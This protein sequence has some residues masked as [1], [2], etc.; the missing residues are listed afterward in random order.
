MLMLPLTVE[1]RQVA[2]LWLL[3]PVHGQPFGCTFVDL[4]RVRVHTYNNSYSRYV[5]ELDGRCALDACLPWHDGAL[6]V[7]V[8]GM[9]LKPRPRCIADLG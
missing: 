7:P 9:L 2:C 5:R 8:A 1:S 6:L 3:L 4:G